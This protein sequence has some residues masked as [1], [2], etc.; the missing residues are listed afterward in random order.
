[1]NALDTQ[2]SERER[3]AQEL[4]DELAYVEKD[5]QALY[6]ARELVCGPTDTA[7]AQ[8]SKKGRASIPTLVEQ[9]LKEFGEM[10]AD[11]LADKLRLRGH[12]ISKQSIT[13]AISRYIDRGER[14]E[15][16]G[17]NKFALKREGI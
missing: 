12:H 13:S 10:H 5:L 14:F 6:R 1:M 11:D 17:R 2:I 15:R 16:T 4:R 8:K 7:A 3:R 9:L